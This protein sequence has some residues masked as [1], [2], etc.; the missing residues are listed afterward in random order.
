MDEFKIDEFKDKIKEY[1]FYFKDILRRIKFLA[2]CFLITFVAGFFFTNKIIGLFIEIT[3]VPDVT[4]VSTSPF[5]L[6]NLAMSVGMSTAFL[7]CLPIAIFLLYGFLKD[8]LNKKEKRY[9]FISLPI[10]LLLF[11]IGFA[12]GFAILYLCLGI[13][14]S[15]NLELG[16]KNFWDINQFLSQII[17][18]SALLGFVFEY[19][20]VLT[21]LIRMEIINVKFL[22]HY[23]RHAMAIIFILV[24]M[25]PPTDGLSLI[26][27]SLP[28]V[29]I[30]EINIIMNSLL[31]RKILLT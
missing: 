29:A 31:S 2:V 27:M 12:Y 7:F 14:S 24:S 8:A 11:L 19:P 5:Q 20:I 23:R 25:L 16:I 18:T 13:I 1:P 6:L 4:V 22:R 26:I 17:S 10:S 30:Y 9:F 21:I 3:N 15:L 28:L